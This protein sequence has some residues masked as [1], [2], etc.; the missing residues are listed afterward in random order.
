MILKFHMLLFEGKDCSQA[1]S[2][3][4]CLR[5]WVREILCAFLCGQPLHAGMV[6]I[7]L[8]LLELKPKNIII[9]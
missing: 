3:K 9:K 4:Y 6:W 5:G 1:K 2:D 8:I 7:E